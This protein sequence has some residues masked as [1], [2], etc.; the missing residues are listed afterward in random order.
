[1]TC[2]RYAHCLKKQTR[3]SRL[4]VEERRSKVTFVNQHRKRL[5][6]YHIDDCI[7]QSGKRCD[8]GLIVEED[9]T[10]YLI[11][12]KGS[13]IEEAC[14]QIEATLERIHNICPQLHI[15]AVIVATRR[16]TPAISGSAMNALKRRLVKLNPGGQF[17]LLA[18]GK[19]IEV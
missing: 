8:Y 13:N 14:R 4:P 9:K 3:E 19:E 1:M 5:L 15:V 16:R 7:I 17:K 11:E 18:T 2:A 10:I 12:L 6:L